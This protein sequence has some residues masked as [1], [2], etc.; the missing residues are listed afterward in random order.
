MPE[1]NNATN[2][3]LRLNK[4]LALAGVAS[5]RAS[6]ELIRQG[7]VK[8]NGAPVTELGTRINPETDIVEVNGRKIQIPLPEKTEHAYIMLYKPRGVVTTVKDPQGRKTVLDLVPEDARTDRLFPVGRL[9][10]HSEG[11]IILTTDGELTY[12]L[13]HPK[14]NHPKTYH[15]LVRGDISED[16]LNIMRRGMTLRGGVRLAPV[17]V[18]VI[19][20]PNPKKALLEMVLIQGINRQIRR[21][22]LDLRLTVESL[23]RVRQGPVELGGLKPEQWR[24]L[25]AG[26]IARLRQS[27]DLA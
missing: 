20:R 24:P 3:L 14:W 13:T 6:D 15:V 11:L 18:K 16:K 9:D 5:R 17:K 23:K 8:V 12:R 27:V 7:R 2:N 19:E 10:Y 25:K 1:R 22:C 4:A 21:M 26:E